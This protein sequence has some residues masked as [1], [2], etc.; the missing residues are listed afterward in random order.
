MRS[1]M[2]G[3]ACLATN[4]VHIIICEY[5]T[6]MRI[7]VIFSCEIYSLLLLLL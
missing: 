1:I 3:T 2:H 4:V 5:L 6:R 7:V